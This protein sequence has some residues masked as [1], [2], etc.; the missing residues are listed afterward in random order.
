MSRVQQF[1]DS[2][3]NSELAFLYKYKYPTYLDGTQ[4]TIKAE[5][6]KR[7]LD[8]VALSNLVIDSEFNPANTGCLR[9]NSQ[10]DVRQQL[11]FTNTNRYT[12]L[13]GLAG[14]AEYT[15]RVE[16]AVCGYL[17]YDGNEGVSSTTLWQTLKR[18]LFRKAK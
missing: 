14:R 9:C 10:Y 8:D 17:L 13:D 18:M 1:L 7:H 15:S 16:C 4:A 6:N 11:E 3:S 2:L 12:G 5:L